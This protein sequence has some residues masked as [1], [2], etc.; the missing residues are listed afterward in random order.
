MNNEEVKQEESKI[1][2]K[3]V[4]EK[5]KAHK[6]ILCLVGSIFFTYFLPLIIVAI[7]FGFFEKE[8]KTAYKITGIFLLVLIILFIKFYGYIKKT[9][10]ERIKNHIVKKIIMVARNVMVVTIA[11]V[12]VEALKESLLTLEIISIVL[13]V[14]FSIGSWLDEDYQRCL[15]KDEKW[16][17]KQEMLNTLREFEQEKD[18]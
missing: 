7:N 18:K 5:V 6:K 1:D 10:K 14:S 3:H 2:K 8:T 12:I 15:E 13:A 16:K 4:I 11:I 9:I 17:S